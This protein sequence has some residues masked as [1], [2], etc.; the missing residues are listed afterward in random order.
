MRLPLT[1]APRTTSFK[2]RFSRWLPPA[3][4]SPPFQAL[5]SQSEQLLLD[6]L[7]QLQT[8]Y[9]PGN[10]NQL[11]L[12]VKRTGNISGPGVT[13][14]VNALGVSHAQTGES[15]T[16][17][18]FRPLY[19]MAKELENRYARP[20]TVEFPLQKW[21]GELTRLPAG[22]ITDSD[23]CIVLPASDGILSAPA[24]N[25][26]LVRKA[27]DEFHRQ[28]PDRSRYKVIESKMGFHI[29]P[30]HAHDEQGTL[31]ALSAILDTVVSVPVQSRTIVEHLTA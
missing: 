30:T 7:S 6:H 9:G 26:D 5:R 15:R 25:I 31:R 4:S 16:F 14:T 1:G 28:N 13:N 27:V 19:D 17:T 8:A 29:I 10:F 11:D 12:F 20:V 21:A 23:H 2:N 18:G 24:L 3:E 22:G